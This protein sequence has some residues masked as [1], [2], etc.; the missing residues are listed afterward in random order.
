[1]LIAG[2]LKRRL[3]VVVELSFVRKGEKGR[4]WL[5]RVGDIREDIALDIIV[6][7][8]KQGKVKAIQVWVES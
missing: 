5:E 2:G 4:P 3:K 7:M 8:V 6:S 1:M